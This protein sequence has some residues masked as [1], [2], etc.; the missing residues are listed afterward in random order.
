[1]M[2][3]FR[4]LYS[5]KGSAK[6]I[7]HLDLMSTMRRSLLRAGVVLSYSQGFNPH[8]Y[9]SVALPLSVGCESKCEL[10]DVALVENVIPDISSIKLPGGIEILD[11]YVPSRKFSDIVW[12]AVCIKLHYNNHAPNETVDKIAKY[13]NKNSL[14]ISKRTKRGYKELD[15]APFIKDIEIEVKEN[16]LLSAKLSAQNPTINADD[17][18]NT[19]DDELK[20]DHIGTTRVGIYD[21][22]MIEFK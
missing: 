22:N 17:L 21:K 3:K 15:I 7:S 8:P 2:N 20:P 16:I 14:I 9:M 12:T 10:I 1:M 19:F 13:L 6:Y 5:K 4:L 11:A 18:I